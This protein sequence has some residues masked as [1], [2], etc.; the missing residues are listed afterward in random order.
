MTDKLSFGDR[1]AYWEVIGSG[2]N[3]GSTARMRA[4]LAMDGVGR[5]ALCLR[6]NFVLR[7]R[8]RRGRLR[9]GRLVCVCVWLDQ[10]EGFRLGGPQMAQ[11]SIHEAI[12]VVAL[13]T[14]VEHQWGIPL[15]ITCLPFHVGAMYVYGVCMYV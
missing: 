9:P 10:D 3:G 2:E 4:L 1:R 7:S 6:R 15:R 12:A 5:Q 8:V 13:G 14:L 11:C